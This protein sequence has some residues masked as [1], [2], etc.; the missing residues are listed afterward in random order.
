[1]KR[2][3]RTLSI[4]TLSALDV[5]AMATGTFVLILVMLMPYY[6][7]SFDAHAE[8]EDVRVESATVVAEAVEQ[9]QAAARDLAAAAAA[10]AEA[11]RLGSAA[12]ELQAAASA[13]Q[14][15]VGAAEAR[16]AAR[17][18]RIEEMSKLAEQRVVEELD[19]IFLV[20]TTRSMGPVLA[21]LAISMKGI[22]R[23]FERLIPSVR[24]GFV[25]YRDR[26][27]GVKPLIVL[28]LTS[29]DTGLDRL[30]RFVSS[31]SISPRGSGTIE[32]DMY[33]GL[34]RALSMPLRPGAKQSIIVIGD[35]AAHPWEASR[36][37]RRARLFARHGKRSSL[38]ALYVS[39][40]SSR[41]F[42][43]P[44]RSFFVDLAAAGG[45]EFSD[46]SGKMIESV[47][48]SVLID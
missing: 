22:V 28:P 20:D 45:G 47:L 26:D 8:I 7:K 38:S 19:L 43:E 32:E 10:R 35:A 17:M 24:I 36:T 29:T 40:P 30:L 13:Q 48:L 18:R 39:T 41:S 23:I 15:Q 34:T 6:R 14:Q 4:F 3:S 33:L 1:M 9:Q 37:L 27:A 42:G 31:L 46:H 11:A 44:A 2:R 21:E 5:L 12:F 25:A 16:K